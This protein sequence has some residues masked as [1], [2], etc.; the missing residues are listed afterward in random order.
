[1][2]RGRGETVMSGMPTLPVYWTPSPL[3]DSE[4]KPGSLL[5]RGVVD[6]DVHDVLQQLPPARAVQ[7]RHRQLEAQGLE[8]RALPGSQDV[9]LAAVL[10]PV[11]LHLEAQVL[12]GVQGQA[13]PQ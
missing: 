10:H 9:D 4:R 11:R 13:E 1:M 6:L 5:A 7:L 12:D 2:I 3:Y 8:R